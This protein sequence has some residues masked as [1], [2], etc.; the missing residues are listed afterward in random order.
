AHT[1][2]SAHCSSFSDRFQLNS[3]GKLTRVDASLGKD[4]A[5]KLAKQCPAGASLSVTVNNDPETPALF[6]NQYYKDLLLHK[7]L[8]QSD[9][10]LVSDQRTTNKVVE[11]A[12]DQQ[13]FLRVG[14]SRS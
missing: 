14:A 9:S 8:F 5:A 13:S 7:G 4:Y 6:D 10:V 11:L 12:N 1:I 2:G 3:K